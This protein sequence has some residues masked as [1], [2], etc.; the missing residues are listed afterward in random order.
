MLK[1]RS[2]PDLLL[3]PYKLLLRYGNISNKYYLRIRICCPRKRFTYIPFITMTQGS[4]PNTAYTV[5]IIPV[6]YRRSQIQRTCQL[7][8]PF[9][10]KPLPGHVFRCSHDKARMYPVFDFFQFSNYLVDRHVLLRQLVSNQ[11][12]QSQAMAGID[13]MIMIKRCILIFSIPMLSHL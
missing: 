5:L 7:V 2:L 9:P 13:T 6:N 4:H 11:Q 10:D 3:Y 8:N 1:M 12:Q